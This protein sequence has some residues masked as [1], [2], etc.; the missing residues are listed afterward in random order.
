MYSNRACRI[1]QTFAKTRSNFQSA[2]KNLRAAESGVRSASFFQI[3][4]LRKVCFRFMFLAVVARW[5]ERERGARPPNHQPIF[6]PSRLLTHPKR[7]GKNLLHSSFALLKFQSRKS[8]RPP[9]VGR[10]TPKMSQ[11]TRVPHVSRPMLLL[12]KFCAFR[13]N[14]T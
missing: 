13:L 1:R 14:V 2:G 11:Y 10:V 9:A 12:I 7:N 4:P 6:L 8:E 3:L 5:R